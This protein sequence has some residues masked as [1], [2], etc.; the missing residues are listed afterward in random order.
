MKFSSEVK[1]YLS[2]NSEYFLIS[3]RPAFKTF[4]MEAS[5][6]LSCSYCILSSIALEVPESATFFLLE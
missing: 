5:I 2:A 1:W 6:F 3:E 4:S